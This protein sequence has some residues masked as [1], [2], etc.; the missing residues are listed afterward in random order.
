MRVIASTI[1]RPP[2]GISKYLVDIIQPTL[3]KNQHKVKNSKSFVSQA[4]TWKIEPDE[5]QVYMMSQTF[6]HQYP[7]IKQLM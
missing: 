6:I 1:G 5:I 7:S 3:N 2:Y 4:Q